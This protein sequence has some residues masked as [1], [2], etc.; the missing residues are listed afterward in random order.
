MERQGWMEK[1]GVSPSAFTNQSKRLKLHLEPLEAFLLF[2]V[3]HPDSKT[4]QRCYRSLFHLLSSIS[5][6][7]NYLLLRRIKS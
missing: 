5:L 6:T 3:N 7:N 4:Y 1:R 2:P